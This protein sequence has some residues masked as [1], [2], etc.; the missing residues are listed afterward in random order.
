M[1]PL[2]KEH[3]KVA[4][5]LGLLKDDA[6]TDI[7]LFDDLQQQPLTEGIQASLTLRSGPPAAVNPPVDHLQARQMHHFPQHLHFPTFTESELMKSLSPAQFNVPAFRDWNHESR[8]QNPNISDDWTTLDSNDYSDEE[9]K[10]WLHADQDCE[11]IFAKMLVPGGMKMG[12]GIAL[13][14]PGT[15]LWLCGFHSA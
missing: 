11:G 14:Q 10:N 3:R 2:W 8:I 6:V 13:K 9:I 7:N 15:G 5:T 4:E 1:E 12:L